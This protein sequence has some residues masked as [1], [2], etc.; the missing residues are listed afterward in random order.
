ML[1]KPYQ[2]LKEIFK[3]SH[4]DF[5]HDWQQAPHPSIFPL[6]WTLWI[7]SNFIDQA[8]FRSAFRADTVDELIASSWITFVSDALDLPLGIVAIA[9]VAKLQTWQSEKRRRLAVAT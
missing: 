3:A 1:W 2:A 8:A 4:P 9:V 7:I 6:W 5:T